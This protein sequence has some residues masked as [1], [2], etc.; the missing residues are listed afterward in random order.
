VVERA[1]AL[2]EG[3]VIGPDA[4]PIGSVAREN[5]D[6]SA[7]MLVRT[8]AGR[9][10]TL[11]QLEE[12]YIDEILRRTGG[13]KVRA[14]SILGIDRKTLYRRGERRTAGCVEDEG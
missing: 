10:V 12:L 3:D 1:V 9:S 5:A 8:G 11:R 6:R 2:A 4:L 13:N 14:A 7:E